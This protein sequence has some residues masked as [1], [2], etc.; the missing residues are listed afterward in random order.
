MV[1]AIGEL[2]VRSPLY[3]GSSEEY[4]YEEYDSDEE[5]SSEEDD[6]RSASTQE[7]ANTTFTRNIVFNPSGNLTKF[8]DNW[9]VLK[10][11]VGKLTDYEYNPPPAYFHRRG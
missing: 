9:H 1:G 11:L 3:F 5:Y 7:V 10:L 8:D 6:K 2:K 4:S